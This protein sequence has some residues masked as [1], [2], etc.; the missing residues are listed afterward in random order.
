MGIGTALAGPVLPGPPLDLKAGF[1][2]INIILYTTIMNGV[3]WMISVPYK[4][5]I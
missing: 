1:M 3:V 5:I 2:Y 4:L